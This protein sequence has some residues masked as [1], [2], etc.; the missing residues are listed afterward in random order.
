MAD[1]APQIG[2][3]VDP[4]AIA[5]EQQMMEQLVMQ[6]MIFGPFME[7]LEEDREGEE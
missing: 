6:M 2:D 1:D 3:G 4:S 7:M 5:T